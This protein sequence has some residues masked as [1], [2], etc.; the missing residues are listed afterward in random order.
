MLLG[1]ETFS[2]HLS[3]QA[4][5]MDVFDFIERCAEFGLDG[6]QLNT[7][8]PGPGHLGGHEL[9]H[10]REVRIMTQDLGLFVEIDTQGTDPEHL[11]KMLSICEA[12]GADVLRLYVSCGGDLT[13]EL[14][15]APVH[16]RQVLPM[17]AEMGVRI[18]V[19]NHEYETAEDVLNIVR[20]VDSEWVGTHVDVGNS[21]MVWE[22]P[23]AAVAA[24]APYAVSSHFKDHIIIIAD[25]EPLVV[26]V[27]LGTGN[28]DC[29]ECFRILAEESPLGRII[30]EVCYAYSAPFRRPQEE[31]AGGRLGEGAFR[32]AEGPF[33]PSWVP[34]S[35]SQ[36]SVSHQW[37][38]TLGD[39]PASAQRDRMIQWEHDAVVESVAFVKKLNEAYR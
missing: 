20:Q 19:E 36:V 37:W 24:L 28:I 13:Q 15:Q 2:Y 32:I 7:E 17:C 3:F 1:M 26:G 18:G 29:G 39:R 38:L 5:K 11:A 33:D 6:V 27:T 12:V 8:G 35:V 22:D 4:G 10:L 9:G 30:I 16:L 31:G 34:P 21:M 14:S 23:V 25:E